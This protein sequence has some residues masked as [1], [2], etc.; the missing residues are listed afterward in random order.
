MARTTSFYMRL[1]FSF[2]TV[3]MLASCSKDD[4]EIKMK[5]PSE[6]T[7]YADDT[8]ASDV[9]RF[10]ASNSWRASVNYQTSEGGTDWVTLSAYSG[11]IG[12]NSISLTLKA[13]TTG[14]DRKA[15]ITIDT[16]DV[17]VTITIVQKGTTKDGNEPSDDDTSTPT[18]SPIVDGNLITKIIQHNYL[19]GNGLL[20]DDGEDTYEFFYDSSNRLVKIVQTEINQVDYIGGYTGAK[21]TE[22]QITI[23]DITY[24]TG[25]VA[26][27]ITTTIDGVEQKTKQSGSIVLENGRAVSGT[28]IDYDNKG[29][30][31]IYK[32][33]VSTYTLTY[34]DNGYLVKSSRVEDG[35]KADDEVISWTN[36]CPTQVLWGYTGSTQLVD[37]ATYG[38]VGNFANLDLNWF[39]LNSEGWD[40]AA[41]DPY[42]IF[43]I[44]GYVGKRSLH[45]VSTLTDGTGVAY[46]SN[47]WL[48]TYYAY[49]RDETSGL[50]L[51]VTE[52]TSADYGSESEYT[53]VYGK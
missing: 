22:T 39:F 8:N 34:D 21:E 12:E 13:N 49:E 52:K 47:G 4:G 43:A 53:I 44:L 27:E 36:G 9:I 28:S 7:V 38:N 46:S 35:E 1:V 3:F 50:P 37:K 19:K 24:Q 40:F 20:E 45:L 10:D 51:K 16:D 14:H 18:V 42:K 23:V 33:Y 5:T 6:I 25:S 2:L 48:H 29:S 31:N 11:G 17:V 30:D 32:K 26:Y 15:T 41:G